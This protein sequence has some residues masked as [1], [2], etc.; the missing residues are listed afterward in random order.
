MADINGGNSGKGPVHQGFEV[1]I[2]CQVGRERK[3]I[4]VVESI[5]V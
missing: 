4:E 2:D 1:R 3:L 5:V